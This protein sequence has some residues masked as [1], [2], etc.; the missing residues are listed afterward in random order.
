MPDLLGQA[1][2]G[3][4][5]HDVRKSL[6]DIAPG[7]AIG[8]MDALR[9]DR[10]IGDF[11]RRYDALVAERFVYPLRDL[12]ASEPFRSP[13]MPQQRRDALGISGGVEQPQRGVQMYQLA[14][15]PVYLPAVHFNLAGQLRALVA[16]RVD[17]YGLFVGERQRE[18]WHPA[19]FG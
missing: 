17:G 19:I 6:D 7:H 1:A 5:V 13:G 18:L 4:I 15:E 10:R 12:A 16:E 3:E 11:A 14:P 2:P 9:F 8:R